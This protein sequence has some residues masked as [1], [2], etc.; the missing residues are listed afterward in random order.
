MTRGWAEPGDSLALGSEL[1]RKTTRLG[2][3]RHGN[4]GLANGDMGFRASPTL[5]SERGRT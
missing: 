3:V 1:S 4:V 5:I 2:A